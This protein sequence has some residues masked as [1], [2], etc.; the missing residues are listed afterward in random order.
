MEKGELGNFLALYRAG[1]INLF[2]FFT[3]SVFSMG[4]YFKRVIYTRIHAVCL[5]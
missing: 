3:A 5:A 2:L 1:S 4:K